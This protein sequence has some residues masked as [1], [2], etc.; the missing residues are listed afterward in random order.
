MVSVTL[1]AGKTKHFTITWYDSEKG[2][3]QFV[4]YENEFGKICI[5]NEYMDKEYI[6][7]VLNELV[8]TAILKDGGNK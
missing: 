8:D 6:K 7:K 1:G 5:D 2:F 4:F 3:G